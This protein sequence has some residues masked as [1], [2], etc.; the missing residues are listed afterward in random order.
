MQTVIEYVL[1]YST[2]YFLGFAT[3]VAIVLAV[4]HQS[5]IKKLIRL[6]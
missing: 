3:A 2:A 5:K 1:C 6:E 4:K